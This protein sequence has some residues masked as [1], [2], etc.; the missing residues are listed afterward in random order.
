MRHRPREF[1]GTGYTLQLL[2]GALL[3]ELAGI[4]VVCDFR[5]R[6]VAAGGQ[7]APLVPAF[8]AAVLRARAATTSR[9]ST[10]A[11]SPT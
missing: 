11:A 6:D 4:D 8:H 9:C 3:A 1:D 10:S 5:S 2:N 7:G